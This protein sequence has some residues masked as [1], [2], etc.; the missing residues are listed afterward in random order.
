MKNLPELR[1][2][3]GLTQA[4]FAKKFGVSTSTVAMWET[5]Q[6][7]P[8]YHTIIRLCDFFA[9]GFEDL[10]GIDI[11]HK[12]PVET[13]RIPIL[14]FVRA[15]I[16]NYSYENIIGYERINEELSKTGDL[17]A[18]QVRGDSME[19]KI[20]EGDIV[21]IRRQPS[22]ENGQTALVMV[23]NEEATIK[24][25]IRQKEGLT[26]LPT[27]PDYLPLYYSALECETLPVTI[28]GLV[29]QLRSTLN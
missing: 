16:P 22:V 26:L 27:N 4:Q 12:A 9:V 25:V 6:R 3:M 11:I 29:I 2:K 13:V 21:I 5:G 28:V 7:K 19:P 14:G 18:L 1:K 8:D 23:G 10:L 24:K 17:F 15:G 20:S